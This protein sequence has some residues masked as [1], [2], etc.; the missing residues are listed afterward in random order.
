MR[1][2]QPA[3]RNLRSSK[4]AA[5][6]QVHRISRQHRQGSLVQR[7]R[8]AGVRRGKQ[9]ADAAQLVQQH[10]KPLVLIVGGA[11]GGRGV[12]AELEVGGHGPVV[13]R[14]GP[15]ARV[16]H[17]SASRRLMGMCRMCRRF[18]DNVLFGG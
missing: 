11:A 14:R 10:G 9:V 4:S 1:R 17:V 13:Q 3:P 15:A 7:R 5:E 8:C 12:E 16:P 2:H 6:H 18:C